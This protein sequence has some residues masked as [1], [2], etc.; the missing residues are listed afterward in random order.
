MITREDG[1]YWAETNT[2]PIRIYELRNGLWYREGQLY[3]GHELQIIG[4]PI[5]I[6]RDESQRAAFRD[7]TSFR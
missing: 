2:T 6:F 3:S 4:P 1:L 7:W 5:E